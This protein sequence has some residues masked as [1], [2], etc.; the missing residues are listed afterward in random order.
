SPD[1][2]VFWG[3]YGGWKGNRNDP[4]KLSLSNARTGKRMWVTEYFLDDPVDKGWA[5]D[6]DPTGHQLAV[7]RGT[8][9]SVLDTAT[10]AEVS[11][12]PIQLTK[13]RAS[14]FTATGKLL[15]VGERD[16]ADEVWDLLRE[17]KLFALP[18]GSIAPGQWWRF[19]KGG[20]F[21]V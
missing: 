13:L 9:V 14:H 16:G 10:G 8:N 3:L 2:T 20:K 11:R 6:F 12:K 4:K 18:K 7:W 19:S 1:G 21:L 17:Q 15:A 5:A